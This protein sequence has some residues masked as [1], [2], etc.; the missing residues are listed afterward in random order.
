MTA[1][2]ALGL[3]EQVPVLGPVTGRVTTS[4]AR[5][6][7]ASVDLAASLVARDQP[8]A[9]PSQIFAMEGETRTDS[10]FLRNVG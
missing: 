7:F 9:S 6:G 4:G 5:S 3:V 8:N 10:S 2:E 1:L